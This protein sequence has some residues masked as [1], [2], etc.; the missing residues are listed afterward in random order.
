[1]IALS[2][3]ERGSSVPSPLHVQALR[4]ADINEYTPVIS[5]DSVLVRSGPVGT[6]T[7]ATA[8]DVPCIDDEFAPRVITHNFNLIRIE[9]M[10]SRC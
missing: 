7:D 2:A 10:I 5:N 8:I 6:E 4:K 1:M 9:S 3:Q